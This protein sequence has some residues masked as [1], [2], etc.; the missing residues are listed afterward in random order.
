MAGNPVL[1][2]HLPLP[3]EKG[4]SP[5]MTRNFFFNA[6]GLEGIWAPA[7]LPEKLGVQTANIGT[8]H[9]FWRSPKIILTS[10]PPSHSIKSA[11]RSGSLT[12]GFFLGE[13]KPVFTKGKSLATG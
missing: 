4:N 10:P 11:K 7:R 3:R 5:A 12:G 9:H 13:G 6:W 2:K 1:I 8:F